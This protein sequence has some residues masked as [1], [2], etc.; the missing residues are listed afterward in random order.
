ME[1]QVLVEVMMVTVGR[2]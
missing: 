1:T 2:V